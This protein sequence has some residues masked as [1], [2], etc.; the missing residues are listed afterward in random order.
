MKSTARRTPSRL[1]YLSG[2]PR[3]TTRSG[4]DASGPRAHVLGVIDGFERRGW[5]V[6]RYIVGDRMPGVVARDGEA[7]V[8][9][10]RAWTL[11][12]DLARLG[13]RYR[14]SRGAWGA[15]GGRVDWVYERFALFQALGAPFARRGIPW[16]LETNALL[17][18]EASHERNSVV[19][20]ALAA[21]LERE[22]Y[23]ACTML[24][25]ISEALAERI[26][27]EMGVPRD[28]ILVVPNG[29]DVHRFDPARVSARPSAPAFTVLFVGSLAPWQGLD[30]LLHAA[31]GVPEVHVTIAGDGPE[32]TALGALSDQLG[33]QERVRFLGRVAP[34]DVPAL[35]AGSDVCY[36]GHSA[37]RSPLKLYEYMA[38]GRPVIS[39][40][41]PDASAALVDGQSGFLFPPGDVEG[42][43]RALREAHA[44]RE[45]L[46]V[47]GRRARQAAVEHH[48]WEARVEGICA[49]VEATK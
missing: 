29:V 2:A 17:T 28:K 37:F 13:L 7:L 10:N 12:A 38:M 24:V 6:S 49:S 44:Q 19:L 21:R 14:H 9:R 25:A 48:S 23:H 43:T 27:A 35:I 8:S 18:E 46:D 22:A 41:V 40:A 36:S 1:G 42:L 34:D 39:S 15:L 16:I 47:M 33:L 26:V 4:S 45:C 20:T 31:A 30:V 5:T 32:R 11:V 3:V